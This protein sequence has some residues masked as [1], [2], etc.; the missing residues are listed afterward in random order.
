MAI[1]DASAGI[2]EEIKLLAESPVGP[3]AIAESVRQAGYTVEPVDRREQTD[4]YVDTERG[5][6]MRRGCGLRVRFAGDERRLTWKAKGESEGASMRRPEIEVRWKRKRI[7]EDAGRLPDAIR[8]EVEPVAYGRSFLE[9]V[10]VGN[11]RSRYLVTDPMSGAT[12][13][14]VIDLVQP[15]APEGPLDPFV[16][17][18]IE[19][20]EGSGVRWPELADRLGREFSLVSSGMSKLERS[21]SGAGVE[22][23]PLKAPPRL[24]RKTPVQVA[25]LLC[26]MRHFRRLQDNEPGT[27]HGG[28]VEALHDMRVSSRRLRAA[29]KRFR[30]VFRPGTLRRFNE[31]MRT[32][33]QTL[34]PARDLD[35]FLESLEELEQGLPTPLVKDLE[36]FKALLRRERE[37]EQ[38]RF[39]EWL[40]SPKRLQA[41][42]KFEAFLERG[43]QRPE[44]VPQLPVGH[45]APTMILR[46]ARRVFRLGRSIHDGSPPEQLH[47]LRIAMKHLRYALED[48][49]DLYGKKLKSFIRSSKD[50]QNVLGA[51]ND[52]EV[53]LASL[54]SWTERLGDE[55][56]SRSVMAVGSLVGVLVSRRQQTRTRFAE[57]WSEFDRKKVRSALTSAVLPS[58]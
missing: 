53:Q 22:V 10:R 44:R 42:E 54:E 56:P 18:E 34:G 31:L 37:R 58:L 28:D 9:R 14:L 49:S 50:L 36:P 17:I 47:E 33:G 45:V 32:T 16:E 6:L 30:P 25:A 46:A 48:F 43:L 21:L 11:D 12:A 2:E 13:E 51:Y 29:F 26:F 57:V 55:L 52:A 3:E 15:R 20:L 27:R 24:T 4:V 38:E 40:G 5:D 23:R 39:L 41:Y 7:P 35:V 8:H 1:S 19:S